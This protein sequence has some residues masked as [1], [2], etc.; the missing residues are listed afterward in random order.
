MTKTWSK[1]ELNGKPLDMDEALDLFNNFYGMYYSADSAKQPIDYQRDVDI[2]D[3]LRKTCY[4]FCEMTCEFVAYRGDAVVSDRE[5]AAY[6]ATL[7][8]MDMLPEQYADHAA[9]VIPTVC[10][11]DYTDYEQAAG[12]TVTGNGWTVDFDKTINK[13]IVTIIN[14]PTGE[15]KDKVERAGFWYSPTFKTWN[16][17]FTR[18]AHRAALELIKELNGL[19]A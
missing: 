14:D 16:K 3:E 11:V 10:S 12:N 1:Q 17:K 8:R 4:E 18:K 2:F 13:T 15:I 6:I 7:R 5:A 9:V 19:A